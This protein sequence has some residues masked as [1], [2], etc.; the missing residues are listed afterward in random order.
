M[1]DIGVD[2]MGLRS[3]VLSGPLTPA[4]PEEQ[5]E[6]WAVCSAA[7]ADVRVREMTHR[8][9]NQLQVLASFARAAAARTD[10][11][12]AGVAAE[13]ASRLVTIASVHD[14]LYEASGEAVA[15]LEF[16]QKVCGPMR[17]AGPQIEVVCDPHLE[18]QPDQL[19]PLAMIASEAVCNS[20]KHAFPCGRSGTILVRLAQLGPEIVLEVSDD[21]VGWRGGEASSRISGL[22]L[23]R[24]LARQLRGR[25]ET[26]TSVSGGSLVRVTFP[27]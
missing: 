21:G 18:L 22:G 23:L 9:K 3:R 19:S 26:A 14:S 15:A 24:A 20:I 27:G 12:A 2:S 8:I 13:V 5:A 6:R 11:S 16:F 10:S 17:G 4:S 7:A 25:L 1:T